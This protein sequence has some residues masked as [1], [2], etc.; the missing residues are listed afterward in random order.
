MNNA[1]VGLVPGG[2]ISSPRG[3]APRGYLGVARRALRVEDLDSYFLEVRRA[4]GPPWN[5][6]HKL[7]MAAAIVTVRAAVET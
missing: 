5:M 7:A 6:D 1:A 3:G 2:G 4:I